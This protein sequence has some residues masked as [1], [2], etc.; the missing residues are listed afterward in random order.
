MSSKSKFTDSF[1]V[2]DDS[3]TETKPTS[4]SSKAKSKSA[5]TSHDVDDFESLK[6]ATLKK[7]ASKSRAFETK[8]K[9]KGNDVATFGKRKSPLKQDDDGD[10]EEEAPRM[11]EVDEDFERE[12]EKPE[13]TDEEEEEGKR[14]ETE[15]EKRLRQAKD[16]LTQL[17][18]TLKDDQGLSDDNDVYEDPNAELVNFQ[19]TDDIF[20]QDE[21]ARKLRR[22][23]LRARG[24]ERRLPLAL[25]LFQGRQYDASAVKYYR[26]PRLTATCVCLTEDGSTA[27]IG[28]KD[29][30]IY[31]WDVETGTKRKFN[32]GARHSEHGRGHTGD[33]Y[34]VAVSSDGVY[35]ASGGKDKHVRIWDVRTGKQIC[36]FLEHRDW[37]TG[38]AFRHNSLSLYSCSKDRTVNVYNIENRAF[39]ETLYGHQYPVNGICALYQEQAYTCGADQ[40]LRVWKITKETQLKLKADNSVL[41]LDCIG[42]LANN[43]LVTGSQDGCLQLWSTDKKKPVETMRNAHQGEWISSC[44]GLY[45]SDVVVSG[46]CDGYLRIWQASIDGNKLKPLAKV[47]VPGYI[48]GIALARRARFAALAVGTEHKFGRW[49]PIK[50]ARN[51]LAIVKLTDEDVD[52]PSEDEAPET[53]SNRFT[54]TSFEEEEF[55]GETFENVGES[56]LG[57]RGLKLAAAEYEANEKKAR[58][59][60]KSSTKRVRIEGESEDESDDEGVL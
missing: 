52:V 12:M 11:A 26:G 53:K 50:A 4:K 2:A 14:E 20:A 18:V 7:N 32:L 16:Y 39:V 29:S 57:Y 19:E 30:S 13:E 40:T 38:V 24:I 10:E 3:D 51:G 1:L 43:I 60:S 37:V 35:L 55:D 31:S 23:A 17:G 45:P 5:K 15:A 22:H 27:F 21:D 48:N 41:S 9:S 46:S 33:V 34:S 59:G 6:R 44:A 58:G 42:A 36:Q 47:P 56:A 25:K 54:Q 8:S 49:K 28:S